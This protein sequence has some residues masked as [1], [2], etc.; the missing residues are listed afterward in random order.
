L[1][2]SGGAALVTEPGDVLNLLE[3]C[4]RHSFNGVHADRYA[5][6]ARAPDVLFPEAAAKKESAGPVSAAQ[7]AILDALKGPL[8]LDE[9]ARVTSL[10]PATLRVE[11]TMLEI[12]RRV[13]RE[14]CRIARV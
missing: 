6:P 14:G 9:L 5:D 10:A 2:K 13:H 1:I 7:R 12:Q 4:A 8:T 11:L 3:S